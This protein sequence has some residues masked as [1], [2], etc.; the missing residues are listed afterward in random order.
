MISVHNVTFV[1]AD[2]LQEL[3]SEAVYIVSSSLTTQRH[4]QWIG[5]VYV[6]GLFV[7]NYYCQHPVCVDVNC[8]CK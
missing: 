1:I 4:R 5:W 3:I 8:I 2:L 6:L 7:L